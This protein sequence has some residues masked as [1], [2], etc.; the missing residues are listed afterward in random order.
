MPEMGRRG[1]RS[2]LR[3]CIPSKQGGSVW[4]QLGS[5]FKNIPALSP[6]PPKPKQ[7]NEE[8]AI[9]KTVFV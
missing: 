6:S 2:P 7:P 1:Q 3:F 8:E 4:Y 5:E 9:V